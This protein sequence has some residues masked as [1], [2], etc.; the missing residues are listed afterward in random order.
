MHSSLKKVWKGNHNIECL[1]E[2]RE[3]EIT[4]SLLNQDQI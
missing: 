3:N 4:I 2:V 1:A